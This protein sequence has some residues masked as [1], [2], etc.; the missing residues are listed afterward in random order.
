[1]ADIAAGTEKDT[2]TAIAPK[3]AAKA[4]TAVTSITACDRGSN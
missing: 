2:G 1:M 3:A 4:R